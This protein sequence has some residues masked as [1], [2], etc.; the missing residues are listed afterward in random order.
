MPLVKTH[1][2]IEEFAALPDDG[3]FHELDEGELVTMPP[4][5]GE[6]GHV[7]MNVT[8]VLANF[9]RKRQLG[10]L[11][12]SDTGFR[13]S[14]KPPLVLA[15]DLAFLRAERVAAEEHSGFIPG[16]P[17]LAVEVMSPSDT[18]RSMQR[19][20]AQYFRHGTGCVWVVHPKQRQVHVY[21]APD[22]VEILVGSQPVT[23]P[24]VLPGFAVAAQQFFL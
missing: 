10:R 4:A 12:P 14:V 11:Y 1:M 8:V 6:H 5:G 9:I 21:T 16:A 19:K 17:D 2:T 13:L 23:A 7:E 24:G 3:M 22:R 20:V 18:A 15:P